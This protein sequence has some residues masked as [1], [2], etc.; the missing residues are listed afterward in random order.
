ME[1]GCGQR[2]GENP[3]EDVGA[4][5]RRWSAVRR[6]PPDVFLPN[7]CLRSPGDHLRRALRR[8]VWGDGGETGNESM[9]SLSPAVYSLHR[10]R[11][12]RAAPRPPLG[13]D[14]LQGRASV[15]RLVPCGAVALDPP[16]FVPCQPTGC[17]LSV[18]VASDPAT[19]P[20]KTAADLALKR[21]HCWFSLPITGG[22]PSPPSLELDLNDSSSGALLKGPWSDDMTCP[23]RQGRD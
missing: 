17:V 19:D 8:A 10:F 16:G 23:P 5:V 9:V 22:K 4:F 15:G 18:Q 12:G 7:R 13:R 11:R 21:S 2:V 6:S 1:A 14:R 3:H 20:A